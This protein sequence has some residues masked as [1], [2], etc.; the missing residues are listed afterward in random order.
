METFKNFEIIPA[1]DK[2]DTWEINKYNGTSKFVIGYLIWSK[3][4]EFSINS[5][6]M[7]LI[8]SGV[9]EAFEWISAWVSYQ[10]IKKRL[11]EE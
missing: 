5:V 6:G 10:T 8:E 7:R 1:K 2:K 9:I 11:E 3:N 4:N